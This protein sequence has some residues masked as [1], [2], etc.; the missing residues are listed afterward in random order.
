MKVR[1]L[2]AL[3]GLC[4]TWQ[5]QAAPPADAEFF[6]ATDDAKVQTLSPQD[7]EKLR[8]AIAEAQGNG[9][10]PQALYVLWA[11]TFKGTRIDGC[12][13]WA[14]DCN[15]RAATVACKV[16]GFRR[17]LPGAFAHVSARPTIVLGDDL[18]CNQPGC[19][20]FLYVTCEWP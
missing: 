5:A 11:P 7:Q 20:G 10:S 1:L 15:N 8:K 14:T 2:S 4:I 16:N 13:T 9:V 18:I 19:G 12:L 17:S 6:R 3:I